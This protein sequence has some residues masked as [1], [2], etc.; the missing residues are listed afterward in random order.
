[1]FWFM[2]IAVDK[3]I[4]SN[5]LYAGSFLVNVLKS[6]NKKSVLCVHPRDILP[7]IYALFKRVSENKDFLLLQTMWCEKP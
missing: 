7:Y 3:Y 1:M 4:L 6:N 5:F 2:G